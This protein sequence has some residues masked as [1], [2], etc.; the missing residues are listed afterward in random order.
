MTLEE[1]RNKI[2]TILRTHGAEYVAVFGSLARGQNRPDSDIDIL[3]RFEKDI[4]L[5][6]HIGIAQELEDVLQQKVD[7]I[8]ERSLHKDVVPYVIKDLMV[9]YGTAARPDL[10]QFGNLDPE[11]IRQMLH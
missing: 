2:A 8:T 1:I 9:L 10:Q 4:S 3:V 7:L 6:D 5:L 11:G